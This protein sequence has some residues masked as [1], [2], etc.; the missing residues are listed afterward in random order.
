MYLSVLLVIPPMTDSDAFDCY[1]RLVIL[2]ELILLET[3]P[4]SEL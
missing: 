2:E 1:T 3:S 4:S